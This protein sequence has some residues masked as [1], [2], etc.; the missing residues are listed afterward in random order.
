MELI[1]IPAELTGDLTKLSKKKKLQLI[2]IRLANAERLRK[3][4]VTERYEIQDVVG[5]DS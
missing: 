3:N 2:R 4:K 5:Y 1:P